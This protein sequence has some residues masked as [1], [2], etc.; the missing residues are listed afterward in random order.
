M[1]ETNARTRTFSWDDPRIGARA[2][3]TMS[4]R[5][6]LEAIGRG[7]LPP[8][9]IMSLMAMEAVEVA[10]GRMVFAVEPAEFH[11]NTIGSVHGGVAATL[12]DSAMGCAIHTLLPAGA[13]YTTLELK[14]NYIRPLTIETGRVICEGR[15]I[16]SGGRMATAEARLLGADGTLYAHATTTCMIF[17][18]PAARDKP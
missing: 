5:D 4:G 11:Y 16:H 14:V 18:P 8:P 2:V 13:G 3:P 17:R 1:S 9:P 12:C 10:E 15:V 6:Y 7:E